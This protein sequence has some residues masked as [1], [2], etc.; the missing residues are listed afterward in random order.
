MK[1]TL[2]YLSL[3]AALSL[4]SCSKNDDPAASTETLEKQALTTYADVVYAN[5]ADSYDA[6]KVMSDRIA[7]FLAAPSAAGLAAAQQAWKDARAPYGQT[8][9]F[10]FY[11]GPIDGDNGLEGQIN[12]WPLDESYIDYVQGNAT[13]GI[14]NNPTTYATIT[15]QLL[16]D[17]NEKDSETSLSTGWHAVEF[18]LWG[19]DLNPNGPGQR[20]FT[21][22]TTAA[23]ATRRGQYLRAVTELLLE[24]LGTV[25]DTWKTDAVYR[26]EFTQTGDAKT[27][28]SNMFRGL[29]ALSKGELAGERMAV[30]LANQDQEDEHSCF[31]DNTHMDIAMN[32]KGIQN[33]YT[34]TYT[35]TNGQ[36]V[37]GTSLADVIG[38]ADATKNQVV[39]SA[40]TEA[41]TNVNA[42]VATAP[43]DR[44]ILNDTDGKITK[45]INALRK[46]SDAIIDGAFALG[47]QV[48][49]EV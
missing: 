17:L 25:R 4:A 22:Y 12:G 35:R 3:A 27:M 45:T 5:Y 30:A 20:A 28:L 21:D 11:G 10:R 46:L 2:T 40:F 7:A 47:I 19:Q 24:N 43:F 42:V 31:S 36:V 6:A 48:N 34:G 38:K 44:L 14:I 18:L 1:K 49:G 33:V 23:N 13:T 41:Q 26:K 16:V 9:A 8:E 29:A 39:L 15:K 32:F 37:K